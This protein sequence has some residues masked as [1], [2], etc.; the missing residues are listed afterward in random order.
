MKVVKY[1]MVR[2]LFKTYCDKVCEDKETLIITR[3]N[4]KNVVMI[5]MQDYN[6]LLKYRRAN[7]LNDL[8]IS[9]EKLDRIA[10]YILKKYRK[11]F[12]DAIK[13]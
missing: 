7:E 3:K 11:D 8:G 4:D 10:E 6:E 13:K 1:S 2:D 12:E 9:E 5:S